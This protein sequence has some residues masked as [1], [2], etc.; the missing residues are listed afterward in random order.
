MKK[1]AICEVGLL[2]LLPLLVFYPLFTANYGY[3]DEYIYLWYN[4]KVFDY[5]MFLPQGRLI[6][7][8]LTHFLFNS[9]YTIEQIKWL[10]LFSMCGWILCIPIWYGIIKKA[11]TQEGLPSILAFFSVFYLI[12]SP[13]CIVSIQWAACLEMFIANTA[14]LVSR[15]LII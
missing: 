12:T 5:M 10:R 11:V 15:I 7:E 6:T 13:S 9:I 14:G 8:Y 3:T 1:T 2:L 4:R